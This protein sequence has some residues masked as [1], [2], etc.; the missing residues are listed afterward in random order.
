MLLL[1][2]TMGAAALPAWAAPVGK[3]T[4]AFDNARPDKGETA[5]G[6]LAADAL[7]SA[8]RADVALLNAASL[9]RGALRAGPIE[10][11][12]IAALLAFP[13][14]EVVTMTLSGA[15]LRAA[16]EYAV[17]DYA[18]PSP[19]FLH[20]AG[21]TATFNARA[22]ANSRL[23]SLRV[24]GREVADADSF[25]VAM[26]RGLAQGGAGFYTVW[27]EAQAKAARRAGVSVS[28]AVTSFVSSR[29]E[30]APDDKVRVTPQ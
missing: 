14:D 22:P 3:A 7:R 30:I 18:T 6:R 1:M 4:A 5:W 17:K 20:S 2:L 16:L 19:R 26:P 11:E 21:L 15:Q 8:T 12:A 24:N 10:A 25:T 28:A 13:D 23:A 27:S 29:G 9:N